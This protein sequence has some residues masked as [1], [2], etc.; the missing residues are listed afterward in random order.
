[1]KI[2][3]EIPHL[4][5][6][7]CVFP[8]ANSGGFTTFENGLS[9]DKLSVFEVNFKKDDDPVVVLGRLLLFILVFTQF[10]CTLKIKRISEKINLERIDELLESFDKI[11][12]DWQ[13]FSV[14]RFKQ[15]NKTNI[16]NLSQYFQHNN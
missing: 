12:G 7:F 6:H 8:K 1:M 3:C 11:L 4:T 5:P 14:F 16:S 9:E 2:V 13:A 10:R 15:Q